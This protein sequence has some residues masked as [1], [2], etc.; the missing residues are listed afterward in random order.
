MI[1]HLCLRT[2]ERVTSSRLA[3]PGSQWVVAPGKY[4]STNTRCEGLCIKCTTKN[5]FVI[6]KTI[7]P[8]IIIIKHRKQIIKIF[9]YLIVLSRV[10]EVPCKRRYVCASTKS[11]GSQASEI[12]LFLPLTLHFKVGDSRALV[13]HARRLELV[14]PNQLFLL[15]NFQCLL[16]EITKYLYQGWIVQN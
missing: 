7:I 11:F 13:S 16:H 6:S 4:K 14:Q 8:F 5:R 9:I 3:S 12:I 10:I 1:V 15:Y 2:S